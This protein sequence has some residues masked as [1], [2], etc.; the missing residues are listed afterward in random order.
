AGVSWIGSVE[1]ARQGLGACAHASRHFP[2]AAE[3]ITLR[4]VDT[5]DEAVHRRES[6]TD[7]ENAGG[8][9]DDLDVHDDLRLGGAGRGGD[10]DGL[11]EAQVDQPLARP[12]HFLQGEELTLLE[13]D[14][15]AQDL[16]L[17]PHV[18]HDVAPLD[19]DF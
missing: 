15:A 6:A 19:V 7:R 9:L 18:A 14:L 2:A 5:A 16:V 13:R 8:P 10:V 1:S 4:D 12:L 17:T 11:E 3:E